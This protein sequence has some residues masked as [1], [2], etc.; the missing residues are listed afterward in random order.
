[1]R[2]KDLPIRIKIVLLIATIEV[3]TLLIL[4]FNTEFFVR[5]IIISN[6]N[7]RSK[8]EVDLASTMIE[9]NL[10]QNDL[11]AV[12]DY[13]DSL[14][15]RPEIVAVRV[16]DTDGKIIYSGGRKPDLPLNDREL[17]LSDFPIISSARDTNFYR[18]S[19]DVAHGEVQFGNID[20]YFTTKGIIDTLRKGRAIAL[21]VGGGFLLINLV[22]VWFILGMVVDPL[23]KIIYS[24]KLISHGDYDIKIKFDSRDEFGKLAESFNSMAESLRRSVKEI[25]EYHHEQMAQ[26]EKLASVGEL[27]TC[28]AH[29]IK[30][31]LAGISCAIEVLMDE[32]DD[33]HPN[34]AVFREI[35]EQVHRLDKTVKDILDFAKPGELTHS[36]VNI[37]AI[38]EKTARFLM[39]RAKAGNV[40]I[41]TELDSSIPET[42][43]D[44]KKIQEVFFN[45]TFN[46]I[47]AMPDGGKLSICTRLRDEGSPNFIEISFEDTGEGI[48]QENIGKIFKPFF[49]THHK[50]TGLGLYI[51][52]RVAEFHGGNIYVKSIPGKGS[53]FTVKLPVRRG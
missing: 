5:E 23:N 39:P 3:I 30:N 42:M 29:E 7:Q 1:M 37:N 22:A 11:E 13:V 9:E 41:T 2:F 46:A 38:V 34:I 32:C 52:K 45:L 21:F 40:T 17:S 4:A 16:Y 43:A 31:P 25:T 27:A 12:K 44:E 10:K 35:L 49:T 50:G 47:Q 19:S 28:L 48:R 33:E 6:L 36:M 26:A 8:Y 53:T 20:V 51:S 14:V 18:V 24:T 15:A